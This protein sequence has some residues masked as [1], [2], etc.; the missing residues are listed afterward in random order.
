MAAACLGVAVFALPAHG[1]AQIATRPEPGTE[2]AL[3]AALRD[4]CDRRIVFLSEAAHGDGATIAFKA[5]LTERLIRRCGFSAVLFESSRYDFLE[6]ERRLQAGEPTTPDMLSSAIGGLWRRDAEFA[7]LVPFLH[8]QARAG[9]LRL[10][11]LDDQLGSAGAFYSIAGMAA[12]LAGAAPPARRQAC[13]EA[14]RRRIYSAYDSA[15]PYDE[16][17]RRGIDV[18]LDDAARRLEMADEDGGRRHARLRMIAAFRSAVARDR[19]PEAAYARARDGAMYEHLR[20]DLR[21]LGDE[22]GVIVWTATVHGA[23]SAAA[24]DEPGAALNM[25]ARAHRDLGGRVFSLGVSALSG[26]Y[27]DFPGGPVRDIPPAD[28]NSLERRA[29]ARTRTDAVY[30]DRAALRRAGTATSGALSN[31]PLRLRWHQVLDGLVVLRTQRPPTV[32]QARP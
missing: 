4:L 10:G 26:T 32:S 30:L 5:A 1:R 9:M 21:R 29:L 17:E 27:A 24:L 7:P 8:E 18:C 16:A 20:D 2:R 31:R 22:R 28:A 25:G 13:Q 3:Q 11:G 23:R 12:D 19:A 14:F 15:R 6:Y